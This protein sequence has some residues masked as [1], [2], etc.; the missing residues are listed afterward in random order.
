M[1]PPLFRARKQDKKKSLISWLMHLLTISLF[2]LGLTGSL[3]T[4]L[5][6]ILLYEYERCEF[7]DNLIDEAVYDVVMPEYVVPL[8][9]N[10]LCAWMIV[11]RQQHLSSSL[12]TTPFMARAGNIS[13]RRDDESGGG[14]GGGFFPG[15]DAPWSTRTRTSARPCS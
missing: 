12:S 1:I 6:A 5:Y 3:W 9:L 10:R 4:T 15:S 8:L 14:E 2:V 11:R 13:G 7:L